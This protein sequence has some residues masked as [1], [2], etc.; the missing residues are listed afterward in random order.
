VKKR[1]QEYFIQQALEIDQIPADEAN[2]IGY[3]PKILSCVALPMRKQDNNEFIARNGHYKISILSPSDIGLPYGTYLRLL[4]IWLV[5]KSKITKSREIYCGKSFSNLAKELGKHSSGGQ[6]GSITALREQF[7]RLFSSTIHWIKDGEGEWSIDSMKIASNASILWDP[8]NSSQWES[9]ITLDDLFFEEI[10]TSA[11]PI[12]MRVIDVCSH[13][14]LAIDIYCWLTS[15]YFR[16]YN[17]VLIP[18]RDLWCQFGSSCKR[19]NHF[20]SSFMKAA[21]R[22]KFFYSKAKFKFTD[23]GMLLFP[24]SPHVRPIAKKKKKY[25]VDNLVDN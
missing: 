22:V 16:L 14:P 4:I 11:I 24:S 2:S 13:Y 1:S 19:K 7:K 20:K 3:A 15:R 8:V 18:W 6:Q 5:T 17:P 25:R 9:F 21:T 23:N 12:D 10:Q